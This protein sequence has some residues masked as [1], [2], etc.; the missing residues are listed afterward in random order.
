MLRDSKIFV[1]AVTCNHKHSEDTCYPVWS[2]GDIG[3]KELQHCSIDF[4]DC[5]WQDIKKQKRISSTKNR[6]TYSL[7]IKSCTGWKETQKSGAFKV[8]KSICFYTC[9]VWERI[10]KGREQQM[11]SKLL[12]NK[13]QSPSN[14]K[15]GLFIYCDLKVSSFKLREIHEEKE[16]KT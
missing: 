7:K 11:P 6:P 15:C 16:I 9:T 5:L 1:K 14:V 3:W 13:I 8:G 4:F 2:F 10:L 12:L